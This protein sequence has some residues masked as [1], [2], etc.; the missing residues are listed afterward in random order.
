MTEH[1]LIQVGEAEPFKPDSILIHQATG[2][3]V[4]IVQRCSCSSPNLHY[5]VYFE[6]AESLSIVHHGD[7]K[8]V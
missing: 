8:E 7:L 1:R 3:Q 6:N 4:R 2:K 5:E